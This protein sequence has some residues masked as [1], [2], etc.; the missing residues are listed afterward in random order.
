M[1]KLALV[2]SIPGEWAPGA[3]GK[4]KGGTSSPLGRNQTRAE[5]SQALAAASPPLPVGLHRNAGTGVSVL[6]SQAALERAI[7]LSL[8][9]Y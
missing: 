6:P 5:M 2:S 3:L 8:L 4:V 9:R 1:I 7:G